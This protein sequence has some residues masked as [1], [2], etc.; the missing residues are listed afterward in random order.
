MA[1]P[2]GVWTAG[3]CVGWVVWLW[4]FELVMGCVGLGL[5]WVGVFGG[6]VLVVEVLNDRCGVWLEVS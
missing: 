5:A 1:W 2:C 6:W 4:G 3:I